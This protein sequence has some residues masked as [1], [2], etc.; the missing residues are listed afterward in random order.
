MPRSQPTAHRRSLTPASPFQITLP[1]MTLELWL[2]AEDANPNPKF[3]TTGSG[4]VELVYADPLFPFPPLN[5]DW[6]AAL[7]PV[8]ILLGSVFR[9]YF[10]S[11]NMQKGTA[12][13]FYAIAVVC[14]A[15]AAAIFGI[16]FAAL[17]HRVYKD[18][19]IDPVDWRQTDAVIIDI[20]LFTQIG[21]PV[22]SFL[23]S[24]FMSCNSGRIGSVLSFLKDAGYGILDTVC[25]AG[26]AIYV[27]TRAAKLD[28]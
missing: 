24:I 7:Q 4:P 19:A 9:F 22:I 21:Y 25:K 2:L 20:V 16:T 12:W 8:M 3:N 5:G 6:C 10:N 18:G 28:A 26:L 14:W 23:E 15:G 11:C 1:L 17:R 13:Y 27:A